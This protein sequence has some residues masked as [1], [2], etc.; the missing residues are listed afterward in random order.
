M[1]TQATDFRDES[2][3]LYALLESL[4][5]ADF[6]TPTQFK[7]WTPNDVLGHLHIWNRAADLSLADE[8]AFLAFMSDVVHAVEN[9]ALRAFEREWREGLAG[10]DLLEAWREFYLPMSE[11][12]ENADPKTRVKWAGPDMS[13]RS[14][15]TARLME[16]WAHGQELYDLVG[17]QRIDSDRIRNIVVLGLNTFAWT[18]HNRRLP[19]PET[20]PAV[21]LEA[22][23]GDTWTWNEDNDSDR[24]E[25][26][27][28]E[29]CQVVTQVRNVADTNLEA[30]GD[31]AAHWMSIAQCFAGPP[32][33][34]PAPGTRFAGAARS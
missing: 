28:T 20:V 31:I 9:G 3:A 8:N 27:A 16:T 26:S 12:F 14:S 17:A 5:D 29:F 18:Y 30:N 10:R 32:E 23:S 4:D 2:E 6:D 7:S 25:G 21:C 1:L 34:P 11:R 15:I 24:I 13:V 33:D 19:V 22:P